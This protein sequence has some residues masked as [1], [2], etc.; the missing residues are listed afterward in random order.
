M[1]FEDAIRA[2]KKAAIDTRCQ[3]FVVFDPRPGTDDTS[4]FHCGD[5][6]ALQSIWADAQR[7]A[8]V[9]PDGRVVLTRD[10]RVAA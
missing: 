1:Q 8:S 2:A 5:V 10:D 6:A 9:W 4:A 7:I 3:T